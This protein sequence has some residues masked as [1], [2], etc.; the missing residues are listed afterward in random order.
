MPFCTQCGE[1][2]EEGQKFCTHC[3][4]SLEGDRNK[5]G[6]EKSFVVPIDYSKVREAIPIGE[7]IIYS[8]IFSVDYHGTAGLAGTTFQKFRSHVL[9]TKNGIAYQTP[10]RGIMKSIY[11][12]W[13]KIDRINVAAIV[14]KEGLKLY[15]FTMIPSK[16]FESLQDFN[17]RIWRFFFEFVPHVINEKK[18]HRNTKNLTKLVKMYNKV[19]N[20]L[21]EEECE[22]F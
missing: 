11:L 5:K 13:Y 3:G 21:G 7:D 18:K 20:V 4:V 19:K 22:F 16:S 6:L 9:F 14:I 17:M 12:P 15:I 1:K 10:K 8:C 2:V